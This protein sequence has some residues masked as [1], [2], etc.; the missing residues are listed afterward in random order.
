[1]CEEFKQRYL[2][3][4]YGDVWLRLRPM[5]YQVHPYRWATIGKELAHIE[6]ARM[7]DVRNF[8]MKHYHPS[9][10]IL[11][12]AG[13]VDTA[14]VKHLVEKWFGSIRGGTRPVR[15][16]PSEPPQQQARKE[17]VHADVP[18]NAIYIAFHGPARLDADYHATDLLT[19]L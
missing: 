6:N 12:I 17:V 10:A 16:L 15:S 18:V 1:V 9:N 4:P 2:N 5:A 7:A 8:F 3:Q 11:T 19:D 14:Q 13:D